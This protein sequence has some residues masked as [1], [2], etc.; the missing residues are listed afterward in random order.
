MD[1]QLTEMCLD[2]I[3]GFF[4]AGNAMTYIHKVIFCRRRKHTT[5]DMTV[6]VFPQRVCR[7]KIRLNLC[8]LILALDAYVNNIRGLLHK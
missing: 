7:V 1:V 4:S 6:N 2:V 5:N 3:T 8:R